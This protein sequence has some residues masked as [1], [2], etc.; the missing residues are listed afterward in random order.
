MLQYYL[1]VFSWHLILLAALNLF[2]TKVIKIKTNTM[3]TKSY[4]RFLILHY[5]FNVIKPKSDVYEFLK[6]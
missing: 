6:L 5:P 1:N 3:T 4:F 2:G